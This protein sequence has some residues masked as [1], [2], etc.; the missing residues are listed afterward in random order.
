MSKYAKKEK[1]T[2]SGLTDLDFKQQLEKYQQRISNILE[3]FT[4]AFFEVDCDW[5]VTYWNKEAERILLMPRAEIIGK[6][7]WEMYKDAIPFKFYSEYHRAVQENVAVRFEEYFPPHQLWF[8]VSAFPS[9]EGLSVY[10]KDITDRKNAIELLKNEKQKYIDLFNLSP[11]PQ[12]LYDDNTYAF[13]QVNEAAIK[14]YGYTRDEFLQMTIKD[15]RPEEDL[16]EFEEL[17]KTQIKKG[18]LHSSLV[19]HRKKNGDII[20]VM[21]EG[22]TVNF[23]GKPT[24]LVMAIDQTE[25]I[26]AEHALAKSELRF[27]GLVQGG[28]DLIAIL[29]Q[30]GV[31]QYVSPT[32]KPILGIEANDLIGKNAFDYIHPEDQEKVHQQFAKLTNEKQ[33]KIF[34]FRFK[35]IKGEYQWIETIIT[36][37]MDDPAIGGIVTNSRDITKRIENEI[38]TRESINRFNIVSEATSDAIWDWDMKSGKIIWN[39]GIMGIFKHKKTAYDVEWWKEQIHPEDLDKVFEKFELFLQKKEPRLQVEYRFRCGTGKYKSVLD[40]SFILFDEL[41]EPSRMIGSMQDITERVNHIKAIEEQNAILRDISWIQAHEVREPLTRI[42]SLAQLIQDHVTCPSTKEHI[43]Y[44]MTSTY[45]LD[46]VI[47]NILKKTGS[48]KN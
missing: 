24:R 21:V 44:L 39:Q 9:G 4:D 42:M 26:N 10:F 46:N 43:D 32:T 7:L 31:Y 48:F 11:V 35:N 40:R 41:G 16:P 13:L 5:T 19:R 3:S 12:W 45:E 15:I 37:M 27:K 14:Q 36:N 23:D 38:K 28:S 2:P 6:N 18:Y 25:H 22:N 30:Q 17:L 47:M 34:P 20:Y 8:E 1:P 29:D 33:I